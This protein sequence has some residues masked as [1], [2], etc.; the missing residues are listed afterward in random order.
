MGFKDNMEQKRIVVTAVG[1]TTCSEVA[2]MTFRNITNEKSDVNLFFGYSSYW[3]P[4]NPTNPKYAECFVDM[5]KSFYGL[6]EKT[7]FS[8]GNHDDRESGSDE[9]KRQLENYFGITDWKTTK[10]EGNVYIICMNSQDPDWDL[11]NKDQYVWLESKLKEAAGLRDGENKIDW[12]VVLVHK[13]L[14]TL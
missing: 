12:I 3:D 1:D 9:T 11:K 6:R 5:I 7:I 14:Y 2:R 4:D 10:Q 13:P 8:L